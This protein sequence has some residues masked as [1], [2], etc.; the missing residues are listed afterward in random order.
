MLP[1]T[2]E[3]FFETF[4]SYNATTWPV[5]T[6]AYLLALIALVAAWRATPK[7]G[8]VVGL[9]LA[10][11]WSWV[12]LV[13]QGVYFSQINPIARAFAAGFLVQAAL[14]VI[15][16]ALARGLELGPRSRLRSLAGAV[17]VAYAMIAYPIIGLAVGESY[18]AMPLFGVTPCPLL[19]FT[20]GLMLWAACAQWWLWILP[21]LWSLIGGSAAV[22][23][24][25][26]Q[27]WAIAHLGCAVP[28]DHWI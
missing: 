20:F 10:L 1:F 28:A 8:R 21:L 5:A 11:M 24:S 16:A 22:L 4:A 23:L 27:D 17:M 13:Y 2:R 6:L 9:V 18:L 7:A 3:Q 14:F 12:G 15:H 25:V 26:P 19:I